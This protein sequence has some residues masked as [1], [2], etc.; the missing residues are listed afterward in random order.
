MPRAR[1]ELANVIGGMWVFAEEQRMG[2]NRVVPVF[3][4]MDSRNSK[5][6]SQMGIS[7]HFLEQMRMQR[8]CELCDQLAVTVRAHQVQAVHRAGLPQDWGSRE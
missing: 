6:V 1:K 4:K 2:R 8:F 7:G 3:R 5:W